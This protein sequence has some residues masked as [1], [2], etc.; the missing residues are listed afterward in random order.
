MATILWLCANA[1][2]M[3][4]IFSSTYFVIRQSAFTVRLLDTF[5]H[6]ALHK[7]MSHQVFF[8]KC[9]Q[10]SIVRH[11]LFF[12][13][14]WWSK[15]GFIAHY[16]GYQLLCAKFENS[17]V[18]TSV[19]W[20]CKKKQKRG[21][22]IWPSLSPQLNGVDIKYSERRR[23]NASTI[24]FQSLRALALLAQKCHNFTFRSLHLKNGQKLNIHR[25]RSKFVSRAILLRWLT[26]WPLK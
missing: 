23:R 12:I 6:T 18:V 22:H 25:I 10:F 20:K 8:V 26:L 2:T 17:N 21:Y 16:L 4:N 15:K 7:K 11:F 24:T 9:E 14:F 5:G 3:I 19:V 13:R 1:H